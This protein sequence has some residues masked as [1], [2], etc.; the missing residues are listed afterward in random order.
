MGLERKASIIV[1]FALVSMSSSVGAQTEDHF[2]ITGRYQLERVT[3]I[4]I[5]RQGDLETAQLTP[6]GPLL[7]RLSFANR[8]GN[9]GL[10][11]GADAY[12][13]IGK[14]SYVYAAAAY[15]D[16]RGVFVPFRAA[17][18]PYFNLNNG[19]ETS[20]GL[21]YIAVSGADVVTYTGTVARYIGNYWISGR[22][23]VSV[24]SGK[25][26]LSG[27]VTTRKYYAD[28]YDYIGLT[29]SGN[30]GPDPEAKDPLRLIRPGQL[31]SYGVRGE[32][33]KPLAN[34]RTRIMVAAGY[35]REQ[36]AA[37]RFRNH[38]LVVLGL[39]WFRR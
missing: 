21:R 6:V 24:Q 10:Q 28:R 19:W 14:R 34:S 9:S 36:V 23:S 22:P 32:R 31:K 5:W 33:R 8:Y 18:E 15:S 27:A 39:E 2:R 3:G 12:P 25:T 7:G 29:I 26:S 4:S 13:R 38:A 16:D 35:E 37:S 11:F 30:S 20:A 1:L 17:L